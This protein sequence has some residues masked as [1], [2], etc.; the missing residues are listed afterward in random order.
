MRRGVW[1]GPAADP[2]RGNLQTGLFRREGGTGEDGGTAEG[3]QGVEAGQETVIRENGADQ[4]RGEN[5]EA[6]IKEAAVG[7]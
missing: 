5:R 7:A 4:E 1:Q 2:G 3:E 6:G